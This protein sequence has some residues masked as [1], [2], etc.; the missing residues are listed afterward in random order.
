MLDIKF[1]RENKDIVAAGAK[2]KRVEVDLDK[3]L[4]LD[5][6]RLEKLKEV[7]GLRGEMNR[8]S[9]DIG[10]DQDPKLK[11]QLIEEMRLVKED[12][13]K[14]EEELKKIMEEWQ[15][16]MLEV[17]NVP[18]PDTPE[19]PDES[20]NVVIRTW[21][22]KPNFDFKAKD[23]MEIGEALGIIDNTTA[24]E[25][26]GARFTYLKGD[27]VRMQFAILNFLIGILTDE[28]TLESIIK[29]KNL[30]I[31]AKPFVPVI[32]PFMIRPNPFL[33]MGRLF[34]KEDRYYIPSDDLY[35]IG[36][37]EHTLGT[38]HM[39]H[40]FTEADLPVR[41]VGY[42]PAFR[43]EAGTY[44][45]DTRGI[46]RVHQ[47]EKLEVESFCLPENSL[48]EQELFVA[49]QEHILQALKLP[50]E[51]MM[52]CTGDMGKPDYRQI[53]INTWMP[54]QNSYRETHTADLMTSFQ[55]RRLNT[56]VKRAD[57]KVDIV[58]MNDATVAAMGRLLI[59]IIEN[60][61]QADGSVKIPEVLRPYMGGQEFIK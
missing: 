24:A 53:D 47:F 17:P 37:A 4:K 2:K 41:Y 7:E 46:L 29:E 26:A 39:D 12:L 14:K 43:R 25:V 1:I 49:I 10:R 27:L 13:K 31:S 21:G 23:H 55:A 59:A 3:L 22:E 51:V 60:Y 8:V 54:G 5:D 58:H 45:K 35:L 56:K 30:N 15:S 18:S 50:Y 36:S 32:P 16:L 61:Q 34:P 40:T 57:G 44:G 9:N 33:K 6:E 11:V 20:G 42:S 52:I 28:K 19:G 38:M 48:K